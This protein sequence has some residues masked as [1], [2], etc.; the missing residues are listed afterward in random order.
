MRGGVPESRGRCSRSSGFVPISSV[1]FCIASEIEIRSKDCNPKSS[2]LDRSGFCPSPKC[3]ARDH[4]AAAGNKHR[5]NIL[6]PSI[7]SSKTQWTNWQGQNHAA[8]SVVNSNLPITQ[9]R[10]EDWMRPAICGKNLRV[11]SQCWKA[12]R[13]NERHST[14]L[15]RGEP[16]IGNRCAALPLCRNLHSCGAV[17]SSVF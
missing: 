3:Q 16:G 4:D 12:A 5:D 1:N 17:G 2:A 8:C 11:A 14:H 6:C 15:F 10:G 9:H 13:P 7:V